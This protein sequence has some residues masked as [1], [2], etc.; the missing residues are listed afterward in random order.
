MGYGVPLNFLKL[1]NAIL[2]RDFSMEFIF[3]LKEPKIDR[4]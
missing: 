1:S 3:E 2:L 4:T